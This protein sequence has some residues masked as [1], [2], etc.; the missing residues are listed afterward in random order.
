MRTLEKHNGTDMIRWT[1][2]SES[3]ELC[4]AQVELTRTCTDW[5]STVHDPWSGPWRLDECSKIPSWQDLVCRRRLKDPAASGLRSQG[6]FRTL[7]HGS[8]AVGP[9]RLKQLIF[10]CRSAQK[11]DGWFPVGLSP[12]HEPLARWPS[13]TF[14]R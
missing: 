5:S 10:A 4:T 3:L 2:D 6:M 12:G 11:L 14:T 8:G 7:R 9:V 13:P 1:L